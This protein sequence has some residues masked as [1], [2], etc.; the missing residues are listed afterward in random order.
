MGKSCDKML[1]CGHH[2]CGFRGEEE[3]L[4]CLHED[5][6]EKDPQLTLSDDASSYCV[7]CYVSGLG[8]AP[9]VQLDCKHVIHLDCLISRLRQ[10]RLSN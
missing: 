1:P 6:V 5:C 2:C 8:E 4:P 10:V 9:C 3:C 7:I